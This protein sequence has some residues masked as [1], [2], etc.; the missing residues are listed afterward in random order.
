MRDVT[1]RDFATQFGFDGSYL[2][3]FHGLV[4]ALAHPHV[5]NFYNSLGHTM[6][7]KRLLKKLICN[8]TVKVSRRTAPVMVILQAWKN[9][10]EVRYARGG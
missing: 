10:L 2:L 4:F 1:Q 7:E 9:N 5:G 6:P 8:C 3:T